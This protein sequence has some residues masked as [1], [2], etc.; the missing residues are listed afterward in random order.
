MEETKTGTCIILSS[1]MYIIR[2][3]FID[4]SEHEDTET[5]KDLLGTKGQNKRNEILAKEREERFARLPAWKVSQCIGTI[6]L[7]MIYFYYC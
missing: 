4:Q 1:V 7:L 5:D 2:Y 6:V 3:Y